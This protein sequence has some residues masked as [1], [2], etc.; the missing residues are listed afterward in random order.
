MERGSEWEIEAV[1]SQW[2]AFEE[3]RRVTTRL[4]TGIATSSFG[5]VLLMLAAASEVCMPRAEG[6]NLWCKPVT[7]HPIAA[8]M[9]LL[10]LLG[11]SVGLWLA[12]TAL[13]SY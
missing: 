2:A 4:L 8:L 13:N 6:A 7:S 10:G 5:A 11:L 3:R 1:R 9:S 12:G